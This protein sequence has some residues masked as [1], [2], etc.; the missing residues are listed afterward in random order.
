M[1]FPPYLQRFHTVTTGDRKGLRSIKKL[2]P[3]IQTGYVLQQ[4]EEGV[5]GRIAN[6]GSH[7]QQR[8]FN[9]GEGE[10]E[11]EDDD[12]GVEIY[13]VMLAVS[14]AM[15]RVGLIAESRQPASSEGEPVFDVRHSVGSQV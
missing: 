6:P 14:C 11:G 13:S 8:P 5:G 7:R 4:V 2:L 3:L 1:N 10:G 15:A 9:G 12:G